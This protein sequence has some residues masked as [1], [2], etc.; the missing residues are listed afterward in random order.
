MI[1]QPNDIITLQV[2]FLD[3]KNRFAFF[4]MSLNGTR[5]GTIRFDCQQEPASFGSAFAY[6]TVFTFGRV[7]TFN[8]TFTCARLLNDSDP[9][10]YK[11]CIRHGGDLQSRSEDTS[12]M[13]GPEPT[14]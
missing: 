3:A 4:A 9:N 10:A 1:L 6:G 7:L 2:I 5:I 13:P 12:R 11:I 14:F 8:Q